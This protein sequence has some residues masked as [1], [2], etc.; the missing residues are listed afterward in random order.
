MG[1]DDRG[2]GGVSALAKYRGSAH[3][4]EVFARATHRLAQHEGDR[5]IAQR[6]GAVELDGTSTP[7]GNARLKR[8][9]FLHAARLPKVDYLLEVTLKIGQQ[10]Q[11]GHHVPAR[12]PACQNQTMQ[13]VH[14]TIFCLIVTK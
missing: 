2:Q 6:M 3:L 10:S 12:A 11:I 7:K 9:F 8:Q 5:Q 4:D 13:N 14:T 1:G